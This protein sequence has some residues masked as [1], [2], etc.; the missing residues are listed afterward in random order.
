MEGFRR[1]RQ[2]KPASSI[3]E[4]GRSKRAAPHSRAVEN[5]LWMS[6]QL[7]IPPDIEKNQSRELPQ[8]SLWS[9]VEGDPSFWSSLTENLRARFFPRPQ[10]A[11]QLKSKPIPVTDPFY[12]EPIWIGIYEDFRELFFPTQAAPLAIGIARRSG[13]NPLERPRDRQLKPDFCRGAR[14]GARLNP[15]GHFLA[16]QAARRCGSR[17]SAQFQH[18]AIYAHQSRG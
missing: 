18:H 16:S 17:S 7:L 2:I 5:G 15:G 11:L 3:I 8:P 9:T 1:R 14:I 4:A 12:Q 13:V 10:P 6:N